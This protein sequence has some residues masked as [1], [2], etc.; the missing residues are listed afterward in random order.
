MR[1]RRSQPEPTPPDLHRAPV[2]SEHL[3][4]R[5]ATRADAPALEETMASARL[6]EGE[7][8][9]DGARRFGAGLTEVPVWTATRAV[10][11]KGTAKIVG[12]V[13]LTE[14][15]DRI[16][17]A[18]RIGWWLAAGAEHHATELVAAVDQ[19]LRA[20]EVA[21]VVMHVRADDDHA[22]QVA[23]TTGFRRGEPVQHVTQTGRQLDF[24]EYLRP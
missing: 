19:R 4:I 10:C 16:G 13:V 22:I 7:R 5:E 11:E 18:R 15:D 1:R 21:V 12:G 9:A 8:T 24:W 20:L 23:E 3:I 2:I 14:F 6:E 17:E